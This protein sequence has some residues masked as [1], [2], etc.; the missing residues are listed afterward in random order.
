M[1]VA[2]LF[3]ALR[4]EPPLDLFGATLNLSKGR[5]CSSR[6]YGM[7]VNLLCAVI[8]SVQPTSDPWGRVRTVTRT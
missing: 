8:D 5:T 1:I 6:F 4:L 2:E 7:N 3:V